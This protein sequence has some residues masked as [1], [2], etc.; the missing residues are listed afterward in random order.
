M[1]TKKELRDAL[2]RLQSAAHDLLSG[3]DAGIQRTADAEAEARTILSR[4]AKMVGYRVREPNGDIRDWRITGFSKGMA[5]S[6]L[7]VDLI[8]AARC[9]DEWQKSY[10]GVVRK[11]VVR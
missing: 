7:V 2:R 1:T 8:K 5:R 3:S 6:V 11:L 4:P 10:G 9:A